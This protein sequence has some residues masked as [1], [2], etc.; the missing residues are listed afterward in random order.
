MAGSSA[1]SKSRD[2]IGDVILKVNDLKMHFPYAA[3]HAATAR[4][5]D[6]G[7]GRRQL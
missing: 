5:H 1:A 6:Q 2:G 4:G 7:C 3:G